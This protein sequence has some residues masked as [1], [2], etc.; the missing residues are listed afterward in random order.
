MFIPKK[1]RSKTSEELNDYVDFQVQDA[2]HWEVFL[3]IDYNNHHKDNN[4]DG[5]LSFINRIYD[6]L[7]WYHTEWNLEELRSSIKNTNDYMNTI[8]DM[9]GDEECCMFGLH[10]IDNT[11]P[12][13]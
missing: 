8:S 5:G 12:T 10:F 1:Y 4:Y 11:L 13:P 2:F 9:L 3:M 6:S 7:G